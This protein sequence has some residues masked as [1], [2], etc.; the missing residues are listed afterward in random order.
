M[1]AADRFVACEAAKTCSSWRAWG[2]LMILKGSMDSKVAALLPHQLPIVGVE[3]LPSAQWRDRVVEEPDDIHACP[4]TQRS[5]RFKGGSMLPRWDGQVLRSAQGHAIFYGR[6]HHGLVQ[7]LAGLSHCSQSILAR[8]TS[9]S[10]ICKPQEMALP[11]Y[12]ALGYQTSSP[13]NEKPEATAP[14]K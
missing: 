4:L 13:G 9:I 12:Y 2:F 8:R 14:H 6:S 10:T 1:P 5:H 11:V 3:P 7:T